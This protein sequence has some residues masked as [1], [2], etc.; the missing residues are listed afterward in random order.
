MA[1]TE[2]TA[3]RASESVEDFRGDYE[4][5]AAMM[6]ASWRENTT[7]PY[8]Y[9]AGFL[10]D[11]FRYPGASFTLAPTIYH[12]S[13]PLAFAVGH[14]RRVLFA[15]AQ[16]RVLIAALLTVAPGH[17]GLGYGSV[18]WSEL[19][20]RAE[21]AGFDGVITYCVAGGPMSRIV[22]ITSRRL[23]HPVLE[24][25]P[26]THLTCS[27]WGRPA[28]DGPQ[29]AAT[30]EQLRRAAAPMTQRVDLSRLWTEEEA[31]WQLSRVGAV[32]VSGG[33]EASPAV[34]TGYVMRIADPVGTPC[35][36]IDDILWSDLTAD[37]RRALVHDLVAVAVAA[38]ARVAVLPNLGYADTDPF[39]ANAFAPSTHTIRSYLTLLSESTVERA[40]HLVYLDV[41]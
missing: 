38:G 19:L 36:V 14:P 15:G 28:P 30:A 21:R 29:P 11:C 31:A 37:A 1:A 27:L 10:A 25:A 6:R 3:R 33:S 16:R 9:T 12:E 41:F 17:K 39:L 7:P 26:V 18:L 8:L 24:T 5:L 4:R 23:D 34:L 22:P 40:P 32:S 20:R 2:T 35:L 13:E